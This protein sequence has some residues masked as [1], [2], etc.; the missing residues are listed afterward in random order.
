MTTLSEPS[1]RAGQAGLTS[2]PQRY[3]VLPGVKGHQTYRLWDTV[4]NTL[5]SE[6]D[7]RQAAMLVAWLLNTMPGS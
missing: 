2:G 1:L 7:N 4:A 5:V 6:G 3:V